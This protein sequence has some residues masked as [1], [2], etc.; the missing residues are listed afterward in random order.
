[1]YQV[2]VCGVT[3]GC[4]SVLHISISAAVI[5]D[6]YIRSWRTYSAGG[7]KSSQ[8]VA[9]LNVLVFQDFSER[10]DA[11][12]LSVC[13]TQVHSQVLTLRG[14]AYL[15]VKHTIG[16]HNMAQYPRLKICPWVRTRPPHGVS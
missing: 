1:M 7:D 3:L 10:S 16:R 14:D 11:E 12:V 15:C 4:A 8:T 9:P 13:L 6:A 5:Y 2:C